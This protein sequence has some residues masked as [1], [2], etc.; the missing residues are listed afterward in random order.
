[1]SLDVPENNPQALALAA[2]H[3]LDEV[4]GC[5]RMWLGRPPAVAAGPGHPPRCRRVVVAQ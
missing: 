5:A 4:S 2:R 1:V 3:R